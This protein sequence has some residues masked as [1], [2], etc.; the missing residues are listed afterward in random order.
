MK[1][2]KLLRF[3][4]KCS[5]KEQ[6][7]LIDFVQSPFFNKNEAISR[8][9][10]YLLENWPIVE[11][12]KLLLFQIAYPEANYEDKKFRYLISDAAAL[13]TRFWT[14]TAFE[15]QQPKRYLEELSIF[16]NRDL[17]K[18]Y[19]QTL[20]KWQQLRKKQ[21]AF[22]L[23]WYEYELQQAAIQEKHFQRQRLRQFDNSIKIAAQAYDKHYYLHRLIYACGMLDREAIFQGKYHLALPADWF[24]YLVAQDFFEEPLIK[25]YYLMWQMLHNAEETRHFE[26]FLAQVHHPDL[27]PNLL[28][29]PYLA[30]INY[31][32]RKLRQGQADYR[33]KALDLYVEGIERGILLDKKELSPWTFT[34]VVKLALQL[35]KHDWIKAF[36]TEKS[37]LLPAAFRE[38]ALNY[39]L[40]EVDY[41]TQQFEAAQANLLQVSYSDL[42][43]YLGARILLAKIYYEQAATEPLLS[44]LAAFTIFLKRNKEVSPN[45]RET[46]LHFCTLL[47]QLVRGNKKQLRDF[48]QRVEK[49]ALLTERG[50]LLKQY[51]K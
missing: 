42:N 2:N 27:S 37:A 16:S 21:T 13:V 1:H 25:L 33:Q 30:A 5:P 38:N 47:F 34:N 4:A 43:Y 20:R 11:G 26:K 15:A 24:T 18:S 14:I 10:I 45:I 31:T 22:H 40:A 17:P 48:E 12:D 7:M 28:K 19:R 49:T 51:R 36:I 32:L 6:S 29:S 35:Q 41:A 39:N 23:D 46:C 8:L 50:W 3:L 44:L 9:I